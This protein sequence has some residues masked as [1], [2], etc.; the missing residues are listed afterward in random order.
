MQSKTD[1]VNMLYIRHAQK[2]YHN[3][4]SDAF[5]LDPG[6]TQEGKFK[7]RERFHQL[8][9][10]YGPPPKIVSSPYLRA[11]ETAQIAHDV[12]L[13]ETGS[14]VVITYDPAIGEYLGHQKTRNIQ[15]DLHPETLACNPFP[16]ETWNQYSYR[17]RKHISTPQSGGWYITHGIVIDSIAFFHKKKIPYP[18]ELGGV[19][20]QDGVISVI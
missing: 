7:A 6:L 5:P 19:A 8:L 3:G 13:E 14:S 15:T 16:P 20:I 2:L 18:D 10:K 9:Q 4:G 11:R 1:S 12:I 17:V